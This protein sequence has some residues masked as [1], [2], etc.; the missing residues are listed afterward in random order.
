M[1]GIGFR[2]VRRVF[3]FVLVA[4]GVLVGAYAIFVFGF[5]FYLKSMGGADSGEALS[6]DSAA[7]VAQGA[8]GVRVRMVDDLLR[9]RRLIGLPRNELT[10]LL[11]APDET[12]KFSKADLVYWL[13]AERGALLALD[14]EWM[15]VFLDGDARVERIYLVND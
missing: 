12:D 10:A 9:R 14:S 4:G 6:F 1:G 5:F 13:G 11:G 3:V 7:W 15:L 2:S 8:S